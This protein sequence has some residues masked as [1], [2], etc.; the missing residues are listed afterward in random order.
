MVFS[1]KYILILIIFL[2]I[3]IKDFPP[4]LKLLEF[5]DSE[6]V[7]PRTRLSQ[8]GFFHMIDSHLKELEKL[9]LVNCRWFEIHDVIVFSK[10]PKLKHL[11][12]S[13][14]SNFRDS[15]PYSSVS[16][17]FGFHSLEVVATKFQFL[18]LEYFNLMHFNL[19][20]S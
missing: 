4:K 11:N 17:R 6:S 20:D 14:C 5:I 3:Q 12:L 10:I 15:V 13:C 1:I 9:S 7:T 19:I 18:K 2:Q 16:T 8:S